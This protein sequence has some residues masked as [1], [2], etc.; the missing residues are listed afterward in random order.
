MWVKFSYKGLR[1]HSYESFESY[2]F[3][4][5]FTLVPKYG[6]RPVKTIVCG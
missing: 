6:T 2:Y 3:F 1:F 4:R 5:D